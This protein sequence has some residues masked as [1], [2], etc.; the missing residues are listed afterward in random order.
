MSEILLVSIR[1]G[2]SPCFS[3]EP[4]NPST[5]DLIGQTRMEKTLG[6][7]FSAVTTLAKA[8]G[9]SA[10]KQHGSPMVASRKPTIWG[11]FALKLHA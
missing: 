6:P 2:K 1:S 5:P 10:H 9:T 8:N 7:A 3:G 4:T 11:P